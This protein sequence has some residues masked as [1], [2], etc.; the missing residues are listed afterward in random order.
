MLAEAWGADGT[1]AP[2]TVATN[3]TADRGFFFWKGWQGWS[4]QTEAVLQVRKWDGRDLGMVFRQ[5][6]NMPTMLEPAFE[7]A[8]GIWLGRIRTILDSGADGVDIRTYCHHNGAMCYLTYAFAAPVREA[9]RSLYGRDPRPDPQDY[10]RVRRIRG[11]F[12]TQ[13]M[14]D[15]KRLVAARGRKLITELE[16]GIEVPPALDCRMQLHLNWQRWITEGIVDEVRMKWWTTDSR[17]V[18]EQV[19]PLARRHGVPV[20]VISRCLHTGLDL[21]AAEM[22]EL[23]IG[24]GCAAGF[25]GY[26]FYEQQNLMDLNPE[27]RSTLKG[28]VRA[29]FAR[30]RQTLERMGGLPD[31]IG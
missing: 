10:E 4:N 8:R 25:S 18:H 3:G 27:G 19:L 16:S 6:P 9:F 21:R 2:L 11:E 22:A 31:D 17:F 1:L 20:H 23:T 12:Y 30:A 14:R 28:P 29:Y 15:A 26:T 13:F 5:M 24:G 7:G